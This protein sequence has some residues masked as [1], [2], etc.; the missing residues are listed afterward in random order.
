MK[1]MMGMAM[2]N[3]VAGEKREPS[4]MDIQ[5]RLPEPVQVP[6]PVPAP[7]FKF[8]ER[9]PSVMFRLNLIFLA[10]LAM[11]VLT[12]CSGTKSERF[13]RVIINGVN[14]IETGEKNQFP[15]VVGESA[16]VVRATMTDDKLTSA[17]VTD[18]REKSV[19]GALGAAA[20]GVGALAV[21]GGAAGVVN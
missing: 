16:V 7:E 10:L 3:Q 12:G 18:I 11:A 4:T 21:T 20:I 13:T 5:Q 2:I 17:S 14:V 9:M 6:A 1:A 8:F 19:M 15:W